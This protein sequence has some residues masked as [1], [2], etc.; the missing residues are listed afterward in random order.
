MSVIDIIYNE[1]VVHTAITIRLVFE[2]L[3]HR[4]PWTNKWGIKQSHY[5]WSQDR[6]EFFFAINIFV[7]A[8]TQLL[9]LFLLWT[10]FSIC[11]FLCCVILSNARAFIFI[12]KRNYSLYKHSNVKCE[13]S[14][15]PLFGFIGLSLRHRL[16]HSFIG[17]CARILYISKCQALKYFI[18]HCWCMPHC[19]ITHSISCG[20]KN[21]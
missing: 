3:R 7:F 11:L 21:T 20:E 13:H 14:I 6:N 10:A 17:N 18:L 19:T 1:T 4:N 5:E 15:L 2:K 9:S 12:F 16:V 8:A